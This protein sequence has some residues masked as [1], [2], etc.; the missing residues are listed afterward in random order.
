VKKYKRIRVTTAGE[1][2]FRT[3]TALRPHSGLFHTR[4]T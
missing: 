2:A 4:T 1:E 3:I